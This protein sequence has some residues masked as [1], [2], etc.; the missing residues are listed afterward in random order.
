LE[1]SKMA[2]EDFE[3]RAKFLASKKAKR[4]EVRHFMV[5]L[6]DP[7][8]KPTIK[9][10]EA[11]RPV[12]LAYGAIDDQPGA[13]MESMSG[14]WW[15]ALGAVAYTID[16]LLGRNRDLALSNA[17]FGGKAAIK[18]KAIALATEYAKQS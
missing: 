12:K 10:E 3:E 17:W 11:T 2:A 1:L 5:R 16:H 4:S 15:G 9:L 8:R 18:T 13:L 14:T 7:K 6:F